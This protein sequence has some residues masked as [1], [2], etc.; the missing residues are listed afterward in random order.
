[1]A[2][3]TVYGTFGSRGGLFDAVA[4]DA[5]MESGMPAIA[6]A[7]ELDDP[8]A[9]IETGFAINSR[10]CAR[11]RPI[12]HALGAMAAIDKEA[13]ATLVRTEEGRAVGMR[14]VAARLETRGLMGDGVDR[15]TAEA[16]LQV[17]TSFAVFDLLTDAG[18]TPDDIT[19]WMLTTTRRTLKLRRLG[20]ED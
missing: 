9:F 17:V 16:H 5:F 7:F 3:S 11:L 13:N 19:A 2:R 14:E 10:M 8:I 6:A 20:G 12:W 15:A 4:E 18:L 1:M